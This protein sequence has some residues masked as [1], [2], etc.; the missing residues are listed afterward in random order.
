MRQN[1]LFKK[2]FILLMLVFCVASLVS[3]K[4][5]EPVEPVRPT[6]HVTIAVSTEKDTISEGET[7]A[8]NVEITGTT[9]KGYSVVVSSPNLLKVEDGIISVIGKVVVDKRVDITVTADADQTAQA[10]KTLII[11]A[12][13]IEGQVGELTSKMI[14]DLGNESVTVTGELADYYVDFNDSSNSTTHKYNMTVEMAQNAWKGSWY[15]LEAPENIITDSYRKGE[16]DGLKDQ[17]GNTG[18]GLERI[19]IDKNN[20]VTSSLVKDYISV[21]TLWET[22]HLWNHLGQLI[23]TKFVYDV[24]TEL[25]EYV[26]DPLNMDDLYL[27]TYLSFSLTPMLSDTLNKLYLKVENGVITKLLAQTEVLYYG[28]DTQDEA[29]AMSY[30]TVEITFS[31]FGTTKVSEPV[32]FEAPENVEILEKALNKMKSVKNY[33]FQITDV[34]TYAPSVD[35][36]DYAMQSTSSTKAVKSLLQRLTEK[37]VKNYLSS[38]GTVGCK[39]LVTE[40]AVLLAVTGKY[41]SSLDDKLYHTEYSGYK[42]ITDTTYDYFQYDTDLK[43]LAGQSRRNGTIFDE[44]PTYDFSGSVFDYVGSSSSKGKILHTFMLRDSV[45]TRDIALELAIYDYGKSG[46]TSTSLTLTVTVDNDGNLVRAQIPYSISDVY[47][48]YYNIS[49][50][51]IDSTTFEEGTFDGYVPR[52]VKTSWDEYVTKYYSPTFSTKDSHDENT[53]VVLEAV[54]GKKVA[55]Y[56]PSPA[57]FIEVIGDNIFGPFYNWKEKGTDSDGNKIYTGYISINARS[58]KFDENQQ[59]TNYEEIIT[60]LRTNLEKEG[61]TYS[62]EN[63]DISGGETGRSDRVVCFIK[64][65]IQIVITNNFTRYLS[66]YFYKTGDWKL[67]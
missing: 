63:S 43:T 6:E 57:L 60:K 5:K 40:D 16:K 28:S 65:D 38:T 10:V 48:G 22:Q 30:T 35:G 26:F 14:E 34:Q 19:Y 46:A 11:K 25:Y 62:I 27:M 45:L 23:I 36:D 9:N 8:L 24:E 17:N 44:L 31:K 59:I 21:P 66:I 56:F 12:K 41:D 53:S 37:A 18:H 4:E 2:C 1:N 58:D 50:T 67:K 54:Y 39:G 32:P 20:K 3:C 61:F 64:D 42:K 15:S 29:D 7:L 55:S 33:T 13:T 49:Y 51:N 52:V 47:L